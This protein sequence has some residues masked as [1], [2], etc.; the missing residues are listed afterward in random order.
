[1]GDIMGERDNCYNCVYSHWDRNQ[2][3]WGFTVGRPARPTCGNQ[4]DFPGRM[5][6]CPPGP[7]C[8][9][10][11]PRPPT[12]TGEAVKA[13]PLGDGFYAYVDAADY[14]W[15]SQWNWC[16]HNGYAARRERGKTIYL[17][18]AIVPAPQGMVVDHL[19][20]NRLDDTR[21]NLEVCT[22]GENL[23]NTRKR[24]GT[25][26]RFRGLYLCKRTGKWCPRIRFEGKY[27]YHGSFAEESAAA[28]AYDHKAVELLGEKAPVNFPEEWPPDRRREVHARWLETEGKN[29]KEEGKKKAKGGRPK[30]D[31]AG[32][33]RKPAQRKAKGGSRKA[34]GA[35]RKAKK[36][37]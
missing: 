5:R 4:P 37:K 19:N 34:K 26:S 18:R 7:V 36:R 9:N 3:L 8:R 29:K 17:H 11:R 23:R 33:K 28:R 21:A 6:T 30:A 20:H 32:A 35:R 2:A 1:M 13:I 25:A 12:P 27:V 15:V 24:R 16:L 22:Q 14:D 10:F 31:T